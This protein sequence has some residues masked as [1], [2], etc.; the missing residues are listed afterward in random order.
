MTCGPWTIYAR[1][2]FP[3]SYGHP[4]WRP[5]PCPMFGEVRLGDVGY[6]EDGHFCFLF[7]VT[8]KPAADSDHHPVNIRG[9]P[10]GFQPLDLPEHTIKHRPNEITQPLLHSKSLQATSLAASALL[11]FVHFSL[12]QPLKTRFDIGWQQ[13]MRCSSFRQL[14]LP[15]QG[16]GRRSP[17]AQEAS[18]LHLS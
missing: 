12:S 14:E 9:V 17:Y 4:L 11:R 6:L 1:Q 5:E 7:N 10:D 16:G 8:E 18:A 3:L 15:L 2:L 13:R